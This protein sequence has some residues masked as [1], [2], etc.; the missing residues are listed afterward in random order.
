MLESNCTCALGGCEYPR[1]H[2]FKLELRSYNEGMNKL[3]MTFYLWYYDGMQ[4]QNKNN[5]E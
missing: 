2:V 5:W 3:L 4:N 1:E